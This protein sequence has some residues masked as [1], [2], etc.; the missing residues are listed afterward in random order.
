MVAVQHSVT[1]LADTR[2]YVYH[3]W[4]TTQYASFTVKVTNITE[5]AILLKYAGK[6]LLEAYILTK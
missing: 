1:S 4:I 3:S 5:G 6:N 2:S